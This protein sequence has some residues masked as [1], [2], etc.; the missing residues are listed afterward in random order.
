MPHYGNPYLS[1]EY[2]EYIKQKNLPFMQV[3]IQKN[4]LDSISKNLNIKEGE[5]YEPRFPVY[6]EYITGVMTVPKESHEAFFLAH[7][8]CQKLREIAKDRI[9]EM[10]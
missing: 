3:K 7:L 5:L 8:A 6:S 10:I 2:E 9:S 1:N 4:F